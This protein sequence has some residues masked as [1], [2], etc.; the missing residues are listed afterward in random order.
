ME[1]KT[2]KNEKEK[3]IYALTL[4]D[5]GRNAVYLQAKLLNSILGSTFNAITQIH[6]T[7]G[8]GKWSSLRKIFLSQ[9]PVIYHYASFDF[10]ATLFARRPNTIFVY[11]NQT[12][13]HYFFKWRPQTALLVFITDLQLWL[14]PKDMQWVAVSDFNRQRLL[15]FGFKKVTVCPCIV[16]QKETNSTSDKTKEPSV[17]FVGRIAPH[18]NCI[19]LLS[20]VSK[21]AHILSHR[22]T[23]RIVGNVESGCL[24]GV[25]FKRAIRRYMSVP[26][27]EIQWYPDV[28]SQEELDTLYTSSWLYV[29]MSLHE[30]FGLPICEAVVR[31]TP[32]LY[33]EC[34]G[35]ESILGGYG[36][37]RLAE[38]EQ[39]WK[40]LIQLLESQ[41]AREKLLNIQ[42][43]YVLNYTSPV[44]EKAIQ[45]TYESLLRF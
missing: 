34:G 24:Y 31:G 30:G 6:S 40:Y 32:A 19:E 20:Q 2:M 35:T 22:V 38:R 39:F 13:A 23:L 4:V 26:W 36:M 16:T 43:S 14:F 10:Y 45:S 3:I 7:K 12:P 1:T 11:H 21:A 9:A 29:S 37:V 15:K 41:S 42:K 25:A 33:L 8:L 44:I 17:L 28:L 18:K 27:L 5:S